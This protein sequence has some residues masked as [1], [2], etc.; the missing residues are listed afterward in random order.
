MVRA[1]IFG[2]TGYTG[3]ELVKILQKH[4]Q[5]EVAFATSQ[6]F[7]G[8]KLSD[9]YPQAPHLPLVLGEEAPLNMVDVVFF[10]PPSC[11]GGRN[12]RSRLSG[13]R[14]RH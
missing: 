10:V 5:V 12:G 14:H 2:A 11:G 13:W 1:G 8:Q 6:S 4:P 9:L 7:A 3:H